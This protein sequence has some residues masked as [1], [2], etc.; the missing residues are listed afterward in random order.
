[1]N[2]LKSDLMRNFTIG[3]VAGALF[4]FAQ[5]GADLFDSAIPEAQAQTAE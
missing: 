2:F 4:L 1:M 3:F 5:S